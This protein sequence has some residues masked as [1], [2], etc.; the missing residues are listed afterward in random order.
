MNHSY[1]DKALFP[2]CAQLVV[3]GGGIVGLSAAIHAKMANP[4]RSV[5]LLEKGLTP[6]GASSKNAGFACFG[7]LSEIIDDLEHS[8][9]QQVVAL[10]KKRWEGISYLLKL[11]GK[12]NI[13]YEASGGFEVFT[14]DLCN[15]HAACVEH[16]D[17]INHILKPVFGEIVFSS[18]DRRLEYFGLKGF[19]HMISN[20]FEGQLNAAK[21]LQALIRTAR[22]KGV[23]VVCGAEVSNWEELPAGIQVFL[24]SGQ[25]IK[26]EQLLLATNGFT[27]NLIPGLDVRPTRAQVLITEPVEGLRLKGA[28]HMDRGYYYFRDVDGRVLLGGARN[29]A[30]NEEFTTDTDTSSFIQNHLQLFLNQH[31]LPDCDTHIDM[32]WTGLMGTGATKEP[33]VEK[34][35]NRLGV[36]VRLGGMGVAIGTIVGKEAAA[37]MER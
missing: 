6:A 36:A 21:M 5:V 3:V 35:T 22:Q 30:I 29:L 20:R 19:D 33:I 15:L 12:E 37:M 10:I 34:I 25:E 8:D 24:S 16:M 31:I 9:E 2:D 14:P 28:F 7:S 26:C 23:Y 4:S 13:A 11:A 32:R 17:Y 1:W 18:D 27:G